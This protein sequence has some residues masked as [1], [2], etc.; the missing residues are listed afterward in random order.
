MAKIYLNAET[1]DDFLERLNRINVNTKPAWGKLNATRML[2]HLRLL[3]EVCLGERSVSDVSNIFTRTFIRFMAL[4]VLNWK[5][6]LLRGNITAPDEFTPDAE[7]DFES[8]RDALIT[9]MKHFIQE[10]QTNPTRKINH[11]FFGPL[12]LQDWA[13]VQGKHTDYHLHQFGA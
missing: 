3:I 1:I 5:G 4:R 9:C 12:T 6:F 13:L 2:F 11:P 10:V 7:F 8:E